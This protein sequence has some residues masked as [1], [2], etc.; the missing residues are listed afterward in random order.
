MWSPNYIY[1]PMHD[2]YVVCWLYL[3]SNAVWLC[4]LLSIF[5]FQC[6]MIMW[7]PI[8]IYVPKHY[9]YVVA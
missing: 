3:R 7:S 4:G 9:Y 6:M 8:Y 1:V 5:M 2:D